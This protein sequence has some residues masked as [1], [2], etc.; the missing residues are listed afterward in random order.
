MS[1]AVVA[2]LADLAHVAAAAVWFGGLVAVVVAVG[3]RRADDEPL[4]FA[5]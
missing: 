5:Y 4:A 3:R 2:Y 1:P